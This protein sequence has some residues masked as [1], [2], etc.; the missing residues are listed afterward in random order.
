MMRKEQLKLDLKNCI[1]LAEVSYAVRR[2]PR[3]AQV[4]GEPKRR[5]FSDSDLDLIVC[6]EPGASHS[7]AAY[8]PADRIIGFQ[9]CYD[10]GGTERAVTW[11]E[12]TGY[13]HSRVD[14]GETGL[15]SKRT[16]VLVSESDFDLLKVAE[17][18]RQRSA[19]IERGIFQFVYE[20]LVQFS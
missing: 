16:P 7:A 13:T 2:Y 17:L 4:E 9:L 19:E 5:W 14:M 12:A 18:F 6:L 10:K 8:Q 20:K 15:K 1:V 11:H 3:P